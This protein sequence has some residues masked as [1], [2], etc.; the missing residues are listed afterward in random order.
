MFDVVRYMFC[1]NIS[2]KFN[3]EIIVLRGP[4]PHQV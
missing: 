1:I 2:P 3:C 4:P